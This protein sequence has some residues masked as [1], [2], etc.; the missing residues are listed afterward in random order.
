MENSSSPRL[1]PVLTEAI[2]Q[3]QGIIRQQQ[4]E[5]QQLKLQQQKDHQN[6]NEQQQLIQQQ[7]EV[8][9]NL[10]QQ[11]KE[12]NQRL[13]QLETKNQVI[14]DNILKI[15]DLDRSPK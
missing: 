4:D 1:I 12:V 2:K 10:V 9:L 8:V 15:R 6:I 11:I 14:P 5:I 3:Q 13:A 7:N